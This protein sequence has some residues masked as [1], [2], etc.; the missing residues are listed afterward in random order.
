MVENARTNVPIGSV[1]SY[2]TG[3]GYNPIAEKQ[4]NISQYIAK[5]GRDIPNVIMGRSSFFREP[6]YPT[7]TPT[8]PKEITSKDELL[9]QSDKYYY[10]PNTNTIKAKDVTYHKTWNYKTG[11]H[12]YSTYNPEIFYLDPEGNI[13]KHEVYKTYTPY[14]SDK[15][16]EY[17]VMLSV[18][19]IFDKMGLK[20]KEEDYKIY[21]HT[22][23]SGKVKQDRPYKA[24][25]KEWE[26]DYTQGL[27]SS[28]VKLDTERP[29]ISHQRELQKI[30]KNI[31][32]TAKLQNEYSKQFIQS[33]TPTGDIL[34]KFKPTYGS[35]ITTTSKGASF[36]TD[37][38][39]QQIDQSSPIVKSPQYI[40]GLSQ[41]DKTILDNKKYTD[42]QI[43]Q[44]IFSSNKISPYLETKSTQVNLPLQSNTMFSSENIDWN[45]LNINSKSNNKMNK[46]LKF[47]KKTNNQSFFNLAAPEDFQ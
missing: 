26:N 30:E 46:F 27:R 29:D 38:G 42:N 43:K 11:R 35:S 28:M 20:T 18:A 47:G 34:Y 44:L 40:N 15:R 22:N 16:E 19:E 6:I 31:L 14:S 10:D 39:L 4:R 5:E 7:V 37:Y 23:T 8:I 33:Q 3:A 41:I 36:L 24:F 1:T 13:I 12:D 9:A 21:E 17:N 2:G 32:D 45:S 25:E